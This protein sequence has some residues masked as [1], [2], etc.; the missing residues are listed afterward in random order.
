MEQIELDLI[1]PLRSQIADA[2]STLQDAA[3]HLGLVEGRTPTIKPG[4]ETKYL[5]TVSILAN[6][7]SAPAEETQDLTERIQS[8][9]PG[10]ML[11]MPSE[12]GQVFEI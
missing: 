4:Y 7:L 12:P 9:W 2:H 3:K 10:G 8:E 11:H 6:A 5:H 1:A